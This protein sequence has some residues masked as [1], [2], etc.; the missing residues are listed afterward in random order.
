MDKW[1][2]GPIERI[3]KTG[4]ESLQAV[5]AVEEKIKENRQSTITSLFLHFP[6]ISRSFLHDIVSDKLLFFL[7][8]HWN[9]LSG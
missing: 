5:R 1:T 3:Q 9:L 4:A 7:I 8:A 6:Q 2:D